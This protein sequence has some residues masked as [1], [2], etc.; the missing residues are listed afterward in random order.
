MERE[1]PYIIGLVNREY[2]ELFMFMPDYDRPPLE[3]QLY[4][5]MKR[6]KTQ[7]SEFYKLPTEVRLM[8]YRR[9]YEVLMKE[10]EKASEAKKAMD[11]ENH[12]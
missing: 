11:A 9:E 1:L 4:L 5:F 2:G 12:K 8:L 6:F 3:E 10:N 7:P